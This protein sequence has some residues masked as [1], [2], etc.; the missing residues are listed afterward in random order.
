QNI[1][2]DNTGAAVVQIVNE[3]RK[4]G[5]WPRP[6]SELTQALVVN[7]NQHHLGR[8]TRRR[9]QSEKRVS[10]A[11]LPVSNNGNSRKEK[12]QHQEEQRKAGVLLPIGI[13]SS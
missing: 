8:R 1:E 4:Q 6:A 10:E 11:E 3:P 7:D 5:S 13:G 2:T 12:N 9:G